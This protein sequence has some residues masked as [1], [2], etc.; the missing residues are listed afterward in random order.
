MSENALK[1]MGPAG[2]DCS[3]EQ[4]ISNL[5]DRLENME[6]VLASFCGPQKK[7][8]SWSKYLRDLYLGR[9]KIKPKVSEAGCQQYDTDAKQDSGKGHAS[10][11]DDPLF[12]CS[13]GNLKN[14]N[15][16][17]VAEYNRGH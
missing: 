5:E 13:E 7:S 1:S 12:P 6:A 15:E 10:K 9:P 3:L 17:F 16:A 8:R 14:R 4:R 2:C 11:G